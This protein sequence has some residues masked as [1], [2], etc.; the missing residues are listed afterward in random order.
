MRLFSDLDMV[1]LRQPVKMCIRDSNKEVTL[2]I[3]PEDLHDEKEA[4]EAAGSNTIEATI[5]VYEML[6]AE[7]FLYF[8]IGE[9]NCTARVNPATTA[10]TGDVVKF[11]LDMNKLH[12]FDKETEQVIR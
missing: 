3:R 6:G 1:F 9:S 12:L 8:D 11:A 5:R 10:R 7:V 4:I 2:G